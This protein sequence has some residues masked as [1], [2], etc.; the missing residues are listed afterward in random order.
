MPLAFV[1]T[2]TSCLFLTVPTFLLASRYAVLCHSSCQSN[3]V[4]F[5]TFVLAV[6]EILVVF[7]GVIFHEPK[8]LIFVKGYGNNAYFFLN[9]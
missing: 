2:P 6:S 9:L 1:M 7:S 4:K 3:I 5:S 8:V